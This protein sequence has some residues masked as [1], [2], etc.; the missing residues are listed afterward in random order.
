MGDDA[1]SWFWFS[2]GVAVVWMAL[3]ALVLMIGEE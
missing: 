3:V 2:V 1:L